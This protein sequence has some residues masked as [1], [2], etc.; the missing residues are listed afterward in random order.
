MADN[1]E[2][3]D[4]RSR[5]PELRILTP[6]DFLREHA[7]PPSQAEAP[8]ERGEGDSAAETVTGDDS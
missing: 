6:V 5:F 8:A 2:G 1:A 7:R 3:R 4:F